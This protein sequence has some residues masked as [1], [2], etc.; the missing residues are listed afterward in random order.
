MLNDRDKMVLVGLMAVVFILSELSKRFPDVEW[1]RH[2]RWEPARLDD[3]Q[4]ARLR[5]RTNITSGVELM[6]IGLALPLGYVALKVMFFNEI[7]AGGLTIV[8]LLSLV[9]FG[10]GVVAI[11]RNRA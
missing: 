9:C 2:F 7:T 11:W 8:G 1:L 6:L 10:L 4:R 5:R 3:A